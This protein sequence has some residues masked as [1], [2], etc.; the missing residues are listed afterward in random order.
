MGKFDHLFEEKNVYSDSL[1]CKGIYPA[2]KTDSD[3]FVKKVAQST[4]DEEA[5]ERY[6]L[7]LPLNH[8]SIYYVRF[9]KRPEEL[10]VAVCMSDPRELAEGQGMASPVPKGCLWFE[11]KVADDDCDFMYVPQQ[12]GEY[13]VIYTGS[14]ACEFILGE[15]PVS[16][17]YDVEDDWWDCGPQ[18]SNMGGEGSWGDWQWSSEEF[19]NNVYEPMR[20][21]YPDYITRCHIGKDETGEIDMWAYIYEPADYEQVLFLTGG[22]HGEEVDGYS[23]LGRFLQLLAEEDGSH[24]GMHYLRTKVKLVVVPICNVWGASHNSR[25][26]SEG[27]NLNGDFAN[28]DATE[29]INV[30]WL[31]EQYK[32]EIAC[33]MDFHTAIPKAAAMYYQ[34]SIEAANSL[35]SRKVSNHVFEDLKKKGW[36][37]GIPQMRLIPGNLKKNSKYLQGYFYNKYGVPTIVCEHNQSRWYE[38]HSAEGMETAVKY[39]GNHIIQT[40]LA[41]LKIVK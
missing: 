28:H 30:I 12:L 6:S 4:Q 3:I 18:G 14:T 35:V 38:Y 37:E 39:Y 16:L 23:G 7:I 27:I 2:A 22:I 33:A 8:G 19:I 34:F 11:G 32:N 20:A 5:K 31:F 40:A 29:T 41:K 13:M 9:P 21:K 24:A 26:T 1:Y 17:G 36:V 10:R 25:I 15:N